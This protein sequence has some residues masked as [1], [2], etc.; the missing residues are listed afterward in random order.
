MKAGLPEDGKTTLYDGRTGEPFRNRVM[1]GQIYM[2]KLNHLV[3]DK[4]HVRSI[5][6]YSL[7]TQQPLGG[8]AQFG[9]QRF[10]E[11][12]VWALEGYGARHTLQEMLTIKS[13][14]I[15][16]RA[17]AYESII[18]GES[19]KEPNVPASFNVLVSELKS[20]GFNIQPLYES[21]TDRKDAF[22]ALKISIASP[23]DVMRW[24]HGEVIEPETINYRTQRPEKDGL[25]SERIFGPTK[26][27]ECYCGKYR[28]IRYKG[29]ICD[30][31]GVEVTKSSVRRERIG[32]I[33]LAAP[34][35]HIW[36]LK[37]IPS[38]LSLALDVSSQKLERV[39]YYSAYIITE[40]EE[41]HRQAALEELERELKGN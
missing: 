23:E 15:L 1:V 14:D 27:Y 18:R 24:S 22:S 25:F 35:S 37:S 39:I 26:D 8:K 41:E 7:I 36:F 16:G 28:R 21:E 34:A 2:L 30:K 4:A 32:H 20:L 29:V 38:R 17:A 3:E 12:E 31:C 6:P 10:G 5:G 19:I 9:G 11:M 40:V 13:D 33:T